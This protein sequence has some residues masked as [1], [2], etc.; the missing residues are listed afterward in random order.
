MLQVWQSRTHRSPVHRRWNAAARWLF[1]WSRHSCP[2]LLLLRWLWYVLNLF[3]IYHLTATLPTLNFLQAIS[4]VIAPKVKS[5]IT[6]VRLG[7]FLAIV[8]VNRTVSATSK[9]YTTSLPK[10]NPPPPIGILFHNNTLI[11]VIGA[12]NLAMLWPLAP[13]GKPRNFILQFTNA[14]VQKKVQTA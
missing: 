2:D 11:F 14:D 10:P 5:V 6:V 1:L 8:L 13:K 9:F 7:I 4:L 12:S 3:G